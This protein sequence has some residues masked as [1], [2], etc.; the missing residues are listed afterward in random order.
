[1][2]SYIFYGLVSSTIEIKILIL[3]K[4]LQIVNN[5]NLSRQFLKMMLKE[6]KL[7]YQRSCEEYIEQKKLYETFEEM[8]RSLII[9][10]PKDPIK[11]LIEKL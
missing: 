11:H 5:L 3:I 1:M 7:D 8:M 9:N 4:S 6:K 2:L 10:R